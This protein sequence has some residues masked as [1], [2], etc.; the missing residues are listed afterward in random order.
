[1]EAMNS[2]A[3][4]QLIRDY[5]ET[6]F[7]SALDYFAIEGQMSPSSEGD[8]GL[9]GSYRKKPSDKKMFFTVTINL[10]SHKIQNLQ[11]Y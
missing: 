1:M 5:L 11:E 3:Y 4:D 8:I 7:G 2:G 6:R 9:T 10:A